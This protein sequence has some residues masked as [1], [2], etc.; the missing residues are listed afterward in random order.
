MACLLSVW[1][2]LLSDNHK[3]HLVCCN[4]TAEAHFERKEVSLTGWAAPRSP[5]VLHALPLHLQGI[6]VIA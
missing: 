4:L 1:R 5:P 2:C 6:L 3:Q